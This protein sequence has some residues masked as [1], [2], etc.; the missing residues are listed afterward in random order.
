[1]YTNDLAEMLCKLT[2]HRGLIGHIIHKVQDN[3]R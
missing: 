2:N 1:M 3:I